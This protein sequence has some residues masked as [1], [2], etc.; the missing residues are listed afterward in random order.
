M[1]ILATRTFPAPT[2]IT[3]QTNSRFLRLTYTNTLR[4]VTMA[5]ESIDVKLAGWKLVEV[6]RIVYIRS[7]PH[8]G[9]LAT[10]VEII[11]QGR[12]RGSQLRK[13]TS[14]RLQVK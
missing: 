6:G 1:L 11:D 9:R 7:G 14:S 4:T 5:S 3:A 13:P 10:I 12:V 8:E 2:R